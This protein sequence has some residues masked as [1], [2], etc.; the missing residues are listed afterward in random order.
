MVH[1]EKQLIPVA[2]SFHYEL[3][4]S[5]PISRNRL[6][7][8]RS[9]DNFSKHVHFRKSIRICGKSIL[10]FFRGEKHGHSQYCQQER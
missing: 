6:E 2:H 1:V 5:Q 4:N 3:N 8:A 10:L 9:Q 7:D